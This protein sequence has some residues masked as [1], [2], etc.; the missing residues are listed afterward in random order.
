MKKCPNCGYVMENDKAKFCRKC[1]TKQPDQIVVTD[2][3]PSSP[4]SEDSP[5]APVIEDNRYDEG[6]L[7]GG[8]REESPNDDGVQMKKVTGRRMPF[9]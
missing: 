5:S 7:L 1:G 2:D 6:I 8:F 9:H 3:S 4:V